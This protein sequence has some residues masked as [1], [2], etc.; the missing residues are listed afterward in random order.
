MAGKPMAVQIHKFTTSFYYHTINTEI[1][2]ASNLEIIDILKKLVLSL[3]ETNQ[4][5][6]IFSVYSTTTRITYLNFHRFRNVS[7]HCEAYLT[8]AT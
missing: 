6:V 3:I 2:F 4:T 7:F 5:F 8:S 1:L